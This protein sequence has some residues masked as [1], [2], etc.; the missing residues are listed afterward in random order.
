MERDRIMATLRDALPELRREFA[1]RSLALFGSVARGEARP[2]SDTD[3]L[4]E[5]EPDAR[6]TLLTLARLLT[7]L[8]SLLG[9]GVDLVE[10]HAGLSDSFRA[11]ISRDLCRVA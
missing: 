7:R 8:E 2:G 4:V 9:R 1:V 3:I 10:N 5:F 11:A 6:V